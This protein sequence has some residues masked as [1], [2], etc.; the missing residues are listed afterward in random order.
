ML[1]LTFSC[2]SDLT[3]FVRI[4]AQAPRTDSVSSIP[5]D[6]VLDD[7]SVALEGGD[8]SAVDSSEVVPDDVVPEGF[9]EA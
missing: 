3:R 7:D 1:F 6:L 9:A 2:S 5:E 4:V 8:S